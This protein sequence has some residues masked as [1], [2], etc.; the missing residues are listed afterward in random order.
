[1]CFFKPPKSPAQTVIADPN[2]AESARAAD[3]EATL[4][5]RRAGA[6]SDVLTGSRGIPGTKKL[7]QPA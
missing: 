7:G 6:A 4:R 5:R 1:M 3:A 2:N